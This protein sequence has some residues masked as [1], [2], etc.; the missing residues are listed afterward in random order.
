MVWVHGIGTQKA[1]ESLFDWTRPIIDVFGEW[2]R[3]YDLAHPLATIGENPVGS[4]SVSDPDNAWIE[5]DIPAFRGR[6]RGQW[7]FT[8][9]YWAG[10]V[11][12]PSF[13]SAASYLLGR[14]SGIIRGIARGWGQREPRRMKRL[15]A[16]RIEF[17]DD[18]RRAELELA[19]SKRW[20]VTD[21]LDAVWQQPAVRWILMIVAT[22]VA[23]V[24]LGIYAAL[25]AIPIPALQRR[26]AIAAADTFIVEWFGDLPI[27]LDDKAQSAAIRTRLLERVAW[28]RDRECDDIVL[29][30]HSG[31]T[32][33]SEAVADMKTKMQ[34]L[35]GFGIQPERNAP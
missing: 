10:D 31:G 23:L 26:I 6:P 8:E 16:L 1:R 11:R 27:L 21:A 33:V 28:L 14:L 32:I 20:Q 9:A 34:R 7:L 24:V 5:V 35:T 22:A 18:P 17:A 30:A 19:F 12:P 13:A 25:H 29:L 4:A 15:D 3:E 2:R